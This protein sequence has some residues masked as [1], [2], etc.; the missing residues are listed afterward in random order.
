MTGVFR[1]YTDDSVRFYEI[2]VIREQDDSLLRLRHFDAGLVAWEEPT[3]T[4]DFPL[5]AIGDGRVDF[6]G[7]SFRPLGDDAMTV[8][9]AVDEGRDE[10]RFDYVRVSEDRET[11]RGASDRPLSTRAH[12]AARC[13][14]PRAR[15]RGWQPRR[16]RVHR[17]ASAGERC[18]WLR[19]D[20][21]LRAPHP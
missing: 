2:L 9:L 11:E 8:F 16:A 12:R 15:W 20:R 3:E 4:V 21:C 1:Q 14:W 6:E 5:A 10:I 19:A 17:R 7:M 18:R 13:G